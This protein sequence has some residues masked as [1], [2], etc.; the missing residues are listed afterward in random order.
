MVLR[1]LA[2]VVLVAFV[3]LGPLRLLVGSRGLLVAIGLVF[4][5]I[6]LFPRAWCRVVLEPLGLVRT[7]WWLNRYFPPL[8]M[9]R[10]GCSA[11]VI[12]AS[13]VLAGRC[14]DDD[15]RFLWL[16]AR[17]P[18]C[19][20]GWAVVASAEMHAAHGDI[21]R[22]RQLYLGLLTGRRRGVAHWARRWLQA[23]AARRGGWPEVYV[24]GQPPEAGPTSRALAVVAAR[25]RGR[26]V[27][28]PLRLAWHLLRSPYRF[29][30]L[31]RLR[32]A[33]GVPLP[34][35]LPHA[36]PTLE[37]AV[38]RHARVLRRAPETLNHDDLERL[39]AT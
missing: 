19:R 34:G 8:Q 3:N 17:L 36:A 29:A 9:L 35:P 37:G 13:R 10:H 39:G 7:A 30:L 23:E 20:T 5:G 27:E 24:Y 28:H 22:A 16:L 25:H 14:S 33:L 18:A 2:V 31:F 12:G 21:G 11:A 15:P 32:G 6:V 1:I 26:P 4:V 38:A